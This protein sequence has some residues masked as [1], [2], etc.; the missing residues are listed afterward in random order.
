LPDTDIVRCEEAQWRFTNANYRP[1]S[2]G[3]CVSLTIVTGYC[4]SAAVVPCAVK[5]DDDSPIGERDIRL[6]GPAAGHLD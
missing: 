5:F 3:Q 6:N 4:V 2:R 1:A